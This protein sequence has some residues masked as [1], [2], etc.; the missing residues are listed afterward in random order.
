M[1]YVFAIGISLLVALI[2]VSILK[3]GMKNVSEKEEADHYISSELSLT[4][5][6]DR[7]THKTTTRRKVETDSAPKAHSGK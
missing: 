2:V 5:R 7:F 1:G 4:Q 6:T 3:A